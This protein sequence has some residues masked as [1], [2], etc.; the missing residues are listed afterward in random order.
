MPQMTLLEQIRDT[1]RPALGRKAPPLVYLFVPFRHTCESLEQKVTKNTKEFWFSPSAKQKL[2]SSCAL[3]ASVQTLLRLAGNPRQSCLVP[4]A[5]GLILLLAPLQA[6]G[7]APLFARFTSDRPSPYAGEAFRLTLRIYISG[8]NVDK[9]VSISGL[10]APPELQLRGFEELPLEVETLD[11]IPYEV[12]PF[13]T[14]ARASQSGSLKLAPQLDVT[15]IQTTRSFFFTQE[16]RR[17]ARMV[18]EAFILPIRTRRERGQPDSFSGLVGQYRFTVAAT[19]LNIARRDLITLT[20][21]VEGDWIPD[22]FIMPRLENT[23]DLKVYE[24]KLDAEESSPT[25]Q[26]CRQ[27]VVP[28]EHSPALLPELTLC[29][30]DT[31]LD[32]YK[33]QTAGPFPVTFHAERITPRQDYVPQGQNSNSGAA[34]APATPASI[35]APRDPFWI[36][37]RDRLTGIRNLVIRGQGDIS[38]RLAPDEASRE[39]FTLKPGE[40]VRQETRQEDWLRISCPKGIGWVSGQATEPLVR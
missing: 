7:S 39:L 26:V 27:T 28:Q 11:G 40:V 18:A 31:R 25:R 29:T 5:L 8:G 23:P 6:S 30:F 13:Q 22:T 35:L 32:T 16:S 37:L 3:R 38:V 24:M 17:P 36:R 2:I 14:W 15:W 12:R 20:A 19:P 10:P 34:L 33:T 21:T 9:Q 1:L 4:P